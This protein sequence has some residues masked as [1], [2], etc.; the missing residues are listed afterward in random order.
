[1]SD[2]TGGS[3]SE[4]RAPVTPEQTQ[5]GKRRLLRNA[6]IRIAALAVVIYKVLGEAGPWTAAAFALL[7]LCFELYERQVRA[8]VEVGAQIQRLAGELKRRYLH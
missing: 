7:F 3:P 1:V 2:P 6:L 8:L 4:G 5:K